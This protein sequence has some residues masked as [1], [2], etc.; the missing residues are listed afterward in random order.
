[1]SS[2]LLDH[3]L[4]TQRYFFPRPIPIS[5]PHQTRWVESPS[6]RLACWS[7]F[8]LENENTPSTR[9]VLLHFH[10][11]GEVVEDW[12]DFFKPLTQGLGMDLLLVEYRGYG[13][14]TG[15]P[16]LKAQLE[17]FKALFKALNRPQE[18]IFVFGRSI[19]SLYALEWLKHFP[20][21]SGA[22]FESGIH[23]LKE[24]LLLRVSYQELNCTVHAFEHE[25][26]ETFH[27]PSILQNY[28]GPTLFLHAQNDHLVSLSHA[29]RNLHYAQDAEFFFFPYGD[30]N[31]ILYANFEEYCRV[32]IEWLKK[33]C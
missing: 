4:I 10:G 11:N 27:A 30:H 6:A 26:Q 14:S 19:G 29:E 8:P 9:P 33:R 13:Q 2:S 21:T 24:R 15:V 16:Q 17:D 7:S 18:S 23:D 32:L 28:K 20:N 1:M 5:P 12:I 31:S 22:I 25:L 3:P